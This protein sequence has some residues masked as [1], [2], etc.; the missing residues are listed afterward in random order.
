[1]SSAKNM[2]LTLK[3]WRQRGY[4]EVEFTADAVQST[5][6]FVSDV[7]SDR[8]AASTHSEVFAPGVL[9]TLDHEYSI[10]FTPDASRG[11]AW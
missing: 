4:L 7:T 11:G 10:T 1:M 2:S 3:I 6:H 5:W 9:N 8:F